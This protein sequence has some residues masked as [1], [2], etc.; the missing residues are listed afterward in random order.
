MYGKV[1]EFY[2]LKCNKQ[3]ACYFLQN[4]QFPPKKDIR[5]PKKYMTT[6]YMLNII[7]REVQIKSI[8]HTTSILFK[9]L[10][11]KSRNKCE[12][13]CVENGGLNGFLVGMYLGAPPMEYLREVS[14]EISHF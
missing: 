8:T 11:S 12:I 6:S 7:I 10:L 2:V 1:P 5:N 14:H 4:R 9:W 3:N 13:G